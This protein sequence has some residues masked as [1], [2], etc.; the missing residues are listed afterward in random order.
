[1]LHTYVSGVGQWAGGGGVLVRGRRAPPSGQLVHGALPPDAAVT[2][3]S[4]LSLFPE[5]T[6]EPGAS[7]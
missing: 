2:H 6:T 1:M 4:V 3:P 7:S 5:R